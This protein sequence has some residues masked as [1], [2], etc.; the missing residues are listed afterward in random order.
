MAVYCYRCGQRLAGGVRRCPSCGAAIF[1][2]ENGLRN[3]AAQEAGDIKEE[4]GYGSAEEN[5]GESRQQ[6]D[7]AGSWQ[8]T[9]SAGSWQQTGGGGAWQTDGRDAGPSYAWPGQN[10]RRPYEAADERVEGYARLS[11]TLG[12]I[13][14][15]L[16]FFMP[17]LGLPAAVAALVLGIL[18]RRAQVNKGRALTGLV[19]GIIFVIINALLVGMTVYYLLHPELLE[20]LLRRINWAGR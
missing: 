12:I 8:Q 19:M 10:P 1:Y 3:E 14:A 4:T 11:S 17:F 15:I 5:A 6:T 2:D 18:G 13:S 20:D 7:S 9:D 16:C